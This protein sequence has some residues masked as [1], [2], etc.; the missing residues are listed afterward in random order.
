MVT[1]L[2]WLNCISMI[3]N[4]I[5]MYNGGQP[6]SDRQFHYFSHRRCTSVLNHFLSKADV[7]I[8]ELMQITSF[9]SLTSVPYAWDFNKLR[10]QIEKKSPQTHKYYRY[11]KLRLCT[12]F[13]RYLIA[14]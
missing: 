8:G 13:L 12:S 10:V 7:S 2:F 1:R 4:P 5:S 11:R 6:I 3:P 9:E 14:N